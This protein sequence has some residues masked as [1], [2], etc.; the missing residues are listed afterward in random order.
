MTSTVDMNET[1][2]VTA[3]LDGD[4]DAYRR[5]V[6]RYQGRIASRMRRFT[7]DPVMLEELVQDVFVQAY[8]GLRGYRAHASFIHWLGRI[9]TKEIAQ[10]TGWTRTAG[11]AVL[12]G[13]P[14]IDLL[15]DPWSACAISVFGIFI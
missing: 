2:L 15:T 1:Q 11:V 7:R 12:T 9:A 6:E 5:L 3:S 14:L 10:Q 4:A 8:L 13:L